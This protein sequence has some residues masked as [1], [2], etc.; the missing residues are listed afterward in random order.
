MSQIA[1]LTDGFDWRPLP[2]AAG[3]K[4]LVIDVRDKRDR[5]FKLSAQMAGKVALAV[6][7]TSN[8]STLAW[9]AGR[10]LRTPRYVSFRVPRLCS[11][12]E[13]VLGVAKDGSS[14]EIADLRIELA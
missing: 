10:G 2:A 14:G 1:N 8:R 4:R 7:D 13:V 6:L 3:E 5:T 12:I 11:Q 9:L